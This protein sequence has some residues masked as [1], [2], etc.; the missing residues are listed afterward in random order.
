LNTLPQGSEGLEKRSFIATFY[1]F[2]LLEW[3][4]FIRPGNMIIWLCSLLLIVAF[5]NK[6]INQYKA[7]PGKIQKFN[8]IQLNYFKSMRNYDEY[9]RVGLRL[10]FITSPCGILFQNTTVPGDAL[11]KVNSV[12]TVQIVNNLKGKAAGS[13]IDN[14]KID[15][16]RIVIWLF[17]FFALWYGYEL[18]QAREFILSLSG[19]GS[20]FRVFFSIV[21]S[22]IIL[23]AA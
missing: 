2:F 3:K 14:G 1:A 22:R 8:Q 15:F 13:G 16:S 19:P 20:R 6:G 4:R 21:T 23:F 9:A 12:V 7:I 10:L 18:L 5:V 11:A 17:N